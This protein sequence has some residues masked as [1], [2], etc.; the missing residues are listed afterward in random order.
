MQKRDKNVDPG[1][2]GVQ[3]GEEARL[4]WICIRF[5]CRK[6]GGK[7][8]FVDQVKSFHHIQNINFDSAHFKEDGQ[9]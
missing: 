5:P 3:D 6:P 1:E 7:F 4:G 9:F 8:F 2:G